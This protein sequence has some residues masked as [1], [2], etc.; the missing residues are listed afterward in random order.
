MATTTPDLH[1]NPWGLV[2]LPRPLRLTLHLGARHFLNASIA[3]DALDSTYQTH[4]TTDGLQSTKNCKVHPNQLHQTEHHAFTTCSPR[5]PLRVSHVFPR[6]SHVFTT[7]L[8][9]VHHVFT[10]CLP[11]VY[12][13]FTTCSPRVYHVFTT[14]LPRVHHVFTTCLPR[15]HLRVHHVF[16]TCLPR[17][18]HVFTTCSPRVH[19]VFTT[20]SPRVHHVFTTC[21]PRVHHVFTTCTPRVHHVFTTCSPRVALG[22][23]NQVTEDEGVVTET[24][25]SFSGT[26]HGHTNA[27]EQ[28]L[29]AAVPE[30]YTDSQ[31][32]HKPYRPLTRSSNPGR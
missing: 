19:H 16:T 6:V 29:C 15:I 22:L 9:R 7:C 30:W 24:T 28:F 14:C 21:S 2:V 8:P 11:R 12:H 20:C 27:T 18:H 26:K 32:K 31:Q 10:T 23:V 25:L 5:V 13:V 17:V 4:E 3:S 1:S